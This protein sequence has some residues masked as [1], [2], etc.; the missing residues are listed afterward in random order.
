MDELALLDCVMRV[1]GRLD[2][3]DATGRHVLAVRDVLSKHPSITLPRDARRLALAL[4]RKLK[5]ERLAEKGDALVGDLEACIAA[6][7]DD[8]GG[9]RQIGVG[10]G[11]MEVEYLIAMLNQKVIVIDSLLL[12]KEPPV[13]G[14]YRAERE[15]VVRIRNKIAEDKARYFKS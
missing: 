5:R 4:S 2:M 10:L 13:D 9:R 6:A 8:P 15:L 11:R 12:D 1:L 3:A 14:W 7:G